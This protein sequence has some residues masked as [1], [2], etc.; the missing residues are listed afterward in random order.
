MPSI[1]IITTFYNASNTLHETIT[2]VL[3]QDFEDYEHIL[4][5]DGSDDDS[6]SIITSYADERICLLQPGR[7]GRVEALNVGLRAARGEYIAILDADDCCFKQRFSRQ[8]EQLSKNPQVALVYSNA[9]LIDITGNKTSV[10]KF[11][12]AHNDMLVSLTALNPFPHSSVMYRHGL[13]MEIGGYNW[14]CEK[15]IDYNFYL[16]LILAGGRIQGCEQALIQLR[17]HA[18]SWGKQ[19]QQALQMRYG[20]MGLV[21]YYQKQQGQVGI[22]ELEAAPWERAKILFNQWFD[23]MCF[24]QQINAKQQFSRVRQN[25]KNIEIIE[26]IKNLLITFNLD[27]WFWRYRGCN[28]SYPDDIQCF[29]INVLGKK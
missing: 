26:L 22:L 13:A 7:V 15:S 25:A 16:A 28:F 1:S 10:T 12:S 18:D 5:D 11:P 20:V 19:D 2:S 3:Q 4:V 29:L 8:F 21:N 14:R 23:S 9:E 24:Q 27:P 6:C 17:S